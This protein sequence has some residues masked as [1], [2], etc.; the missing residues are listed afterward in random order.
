MAQ[1]ANLKGSEVHATVALP[2]E[3]KNVIK[4]IGINITFDP[5]YKQ[6]QLYWK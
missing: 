1:L 3:D 5:V 6:E 2:E 4:K